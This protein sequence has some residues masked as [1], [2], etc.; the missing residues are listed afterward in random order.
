M[1][2]AEEILF[3]VRL[4]PPRF[5]GAGRQAQV[6]AKALRDH[7]IR[8]TVLCA[9]SGGLRPTSDEV[10]G[11]PYVRCPAPEWTPRLEKAAF[12]LGVTL[13]LIRHPRRY[14]VVHLHGNFF[15]LRLLALLKPLFGFAV[16]YKPTMSGKDD[17]QRVAQRLGRT[18]LAAVDRWISISTGLTESASSAGIC[19]ERIVRIP[20]AVE[21]ERFKVTS[22]TRHTIRSRLGVG[23][24]TR[25]WITLGAVISRK[26]G[27]LLVEAWARIPPP[28]PL[29]FLIGP[30]EAADGGDPE[31][32]EG[33]RSLIG[34]CGLAAD[35]HLLGRREDVPE[36][37]SAADGFVLASRQEGLPGSV[38]EALAGGLPVVVTSS[39]ADPDL[40]ALGGDRVRIVP[41]EPSALAQAVSEAPRTRLVP[42]PVLHLDPGEVAR[43]YERVYRELIADPD[44]PRA[45]DASDELQ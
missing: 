35:V 38:L 18:G 9:K 20:S 41:P 45:P 31:F 34:D 1:T 14:G 43:R 4:A 8:V 22:S 32:A 12:V 13:H 26:R 30:T 7:G 40:R 24:D 15:V 42:S 2:G 5:S 25:L 37:V 39:Q 19:A 10:D 21:L 44:H 23:E 36:L 16:V 17:A 3:L 28:R 33:L 6:L 27:D 29:L 11:V